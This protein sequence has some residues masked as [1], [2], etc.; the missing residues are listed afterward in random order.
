[1]CG[2][3]RLLVWVVTHF[4][5]ISRWRKKKGF[6]LLFFFFLTPGPWPRI[7]FKHTGGFRICVWK[8]LPDCDP[9][10]C[11]IIVRHCCCNFGCKD[12]WV[13]RRPTEHKKHMY[14]SRIWFIIMQTASKKCKKNK[15]K[16]YFFSFFSFVRDGWAPLRDLKRIFKYW[17]WF[18]C[19]A[20][21]TA[22]TDGVSYKVRRRKKNSSCEFYL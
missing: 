14:T 19:A 9:H 16:N 4:F 18:P 8:F 7:G 3:S 1:M 13:T 21:T 12:D 22:P 2:C 6:P 11:G 15:N 5:F 10:A 17:I 20:T